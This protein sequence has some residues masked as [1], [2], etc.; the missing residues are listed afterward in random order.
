MAALDND[1]AVWMPASCLE[2]AFDAPS[3]WSVINLQP[4]QASDAFRSILARD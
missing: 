2:E 4:A 1:N 3:E